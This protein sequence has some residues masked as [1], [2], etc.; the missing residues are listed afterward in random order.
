[1]G[2]A[3]ADWPV[4]PVYQPGGLIDHSPCDSPGR[5]PSLAGNGEGKTGGQVMMTMVV[6]VLVVL[7]LAAALL[8]L[9]TPNMIAAM[10]A[11]SAVSLVVSVLFVMLRA[12]DVA[13]TEAA[14]GAG[15]SA[16]VL[17]LGLRRL[18]LWKLDN[19]EKDDA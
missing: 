8:V 18:G 6:V 3:V 17:A 19:R 14:V 12:P 4:Y 5:C 7:M 1:M 16:M 15:L 13:M 9:V 11:S 10:A 2:Q